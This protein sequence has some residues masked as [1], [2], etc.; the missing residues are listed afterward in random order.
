MKLLICLFVVLFVILIVVMG[1]VYLVVMIVFGQVV[2][3]LQ[4]NGSLIEQDGKVVGFVLIG[5]L[6]DVLK[7]F[8]GWLLVIVLMLYN[9]VGLG[10]LNFGLLNLLFFDQVK[11]CIVV[12]CDVGIDLLKLVLIDFVIVLVSGFDL[13]IMLVVVVYQVECVVK[14]CYLVLDVVV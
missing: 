7:Y 10:G 2:F 4:V 12:L 8:W 1:F 5:Q 13:E 6:F 11:V 14:V 3:L 9:V